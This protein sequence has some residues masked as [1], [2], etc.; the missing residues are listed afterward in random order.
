MTPA[1][2][3]TSKTERWLGWVASVHCHVCLTAS[4][5]VHLFTLIVDERLPPARHRARCGG[6]AAEQVRCTSWGLQSWELDIKEVSTVLGIVLR[7]Q[8][9]I[10]T[11]KQGQTNWL[12]RNHNSSFGNWPTSAAVREV[13]KRREVIGAERQA[14]LGLAEPC[15]PRSRLWDSR[16]HERPREEFKQG[17]DT[18]SFMF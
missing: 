8:D 2:N 1:P 4:P 7:A 14:G 6:Y 13:T 10:G 15:K 16:C 11:G 17:K 9:A 12:V 18:N 5:F 3:G